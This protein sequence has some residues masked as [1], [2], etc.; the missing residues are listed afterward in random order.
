MLVRQSDEA[1]GERGVALKQGD[2]ATGPRGRVS[3]DDVAEVAA[4]ALESPA[5]A[6]KTFEARSELRGGAPDVDGGPPGSEAS[7]SSLQACAPLPTAAPPGPGR[8][9]YVPEVY[10]AAAEAYRRV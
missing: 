9:P 6:R 1:G 5:A 3:R 2:K 10:I 8:D 7:F 4:A